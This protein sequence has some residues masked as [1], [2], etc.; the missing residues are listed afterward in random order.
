[1]ETFKPR[2]AEFNRLATIKDWRVKI[3]TI[4]WR[5]CFESFEILENAVAKLPV[6]LEKTSALG[7]KTYR[8]GFLIVHE[9][10]D[11]V[12]TLFNWWLGGGILQSIT[13][14]TPFDAPHEFR[15]LS[16]DGF[17]ACVWELAVIDFERAQWVENVLQKAEKPDF[18]GYLE[19]V[20][21]G[22]I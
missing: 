18:S 21:N 2:K 15:S 7:L 5:L 10:R 12:W 1:M 20:L 22:E 16:A 14:F 6:L 11:G 13:F 9:G 8:A 4:T 19:T 17:M 3:Y